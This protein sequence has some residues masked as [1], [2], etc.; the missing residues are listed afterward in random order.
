M[1][2]ESIEN[3]HQNDNTFNP[4]DQWMFSAPSFNDKILNVALK[5]VN[6]SSFVSV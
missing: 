3:E 5:K 2:Q 1:C 6:I 4:D